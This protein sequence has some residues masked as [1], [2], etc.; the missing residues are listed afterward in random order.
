VRIALFGIAA[1]LLAAFAG[2]RLIRA[3]LFDT[4]PFDAIALAA[5]PIALITVAIAACTIPA[6]R[7]A[8][9]GPAITLRAE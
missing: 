6:F 3:L 7:A 8:R 1:G 2:G 4:S 9:V 5:A